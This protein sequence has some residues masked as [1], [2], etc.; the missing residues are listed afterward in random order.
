MS[1]AY[2]HNNL[3][4]N[5]AMKRKRDVEPEEAGNPFVL[6]EAVPE[7]GGKGSIKQMT[8]SDADVLGAKVRPATARDLDIAGKS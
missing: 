3:K 2:S 5:P 8:K 7:L 4:A 1:G 6:L